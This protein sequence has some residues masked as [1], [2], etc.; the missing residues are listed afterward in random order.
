MLSTAARRSTS[1]YILI[2]KSVRTTVA[3]RKMS[4][5]EDHPLLNPVLSDRNPF[6]DLEN[7]ESRAEAVRLSAEL[8]RNF[9]TMAISFSI[10][11]G[12][13]INLLYLRHR[14]FRCA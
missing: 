1:E 5:K 13:A 14:F 7:V 9:V 4:Q 12:N 2:T 8:Y 6:R 11:H 10:N 3:S